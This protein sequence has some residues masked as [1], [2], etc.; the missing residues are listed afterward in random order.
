MERAQYVVHTDVGN[1]V[2][3]C[4]SSSSLSGNDSSSS[5]SSCALPR[6]R[7]RICDYLLSINT[8]FTGRVAFFNFLSSFRSWSISRCFV[9]SSRNQSRQYE[10]Q[11]TTNFQS[12]TIGLL[13]FSPRPV[14]NRS[15]AIGKNI[16]FI[17]IVSRSPCHE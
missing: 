12:C 10:F 4:L 14:S 8:P 7:L 6:S 9:F 1:E 16:C 11:N 15:C 13:L 17:N 2:I 5:S 3:G